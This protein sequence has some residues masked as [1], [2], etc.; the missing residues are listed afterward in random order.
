MLQALQTSSALHHHDSTA[1]YLSFFLSLFFS[2]L[3]FSLLLP[4]A[5]SL[6]RESLDPFPHRV[7][8]RT[9]RLVL[10]FAVL[11]TEHPERRPSKASHQFSLLPGFLVSLWVS[12]SEQVTEMS[13]PGDLQALFARIK[14][15]PS[16]PHDGA[17]PSQHLALGPQPPVGQPYDGQAQQ[18]YS[19]PFHG[20]HNPSVS[21][22][23]YTASPVPPHRTT[24]V[25]GVSSPRG[26][27]QRQVSADQSLN[28]LNLLKFSQK[29]SAPQQP[30]STV[31]AAAPQPEDRPAHTRALSASDLVASFA[32]KPAVDALKASTPGPTATPSSEKPAPKTAPGEDPQEF[33]LRLL[34][35][36]KAPEPRSQG[37][38]MAKGDQHEEKSTAERTPAVSSEDKPSEASKD[39]RRLQAPPS[40]SKSTIFT[41]VNPFDELAARSRSESPATG[42]HRAKRDSSHLAKTV[43]TSGHEDTAKA[44][45]STSSKETPKPAE[46]GNLQEHK[47]AVSETLGG[48][49][50]Q[51]D[52][53]VNAALNQPGQEEADRTKAEH[54]ASSKEP[55]PGTESVE[56]P[57]KAE[58]D[59]N[60]GENIADKDTSEPQAESAKDVAGETSDKKVADDWETAEDGPEKEQERVVR[61]FNFPLK[62]FISITVNP[63]KHQLPSI[64]I[65]GIMDVARLK[66]EFDQLD[67]C[68]TSATTEYIVYALAR[69]GG[70]RIIRQD[71]GRDKTVFRF[72]RDRVFNVTLSTNSPTPS[73]PAREQ[74]V[75]AI[76]VS[77]TVYWAPI[78]RGDED[79][80]EQDTM[81]S[82]C[83]VFPPYPASD[84]NPSGGQL[85]TRAKRSS[86][87]PEFFGIGRGKNIYIISPRHAASVTYGVSG[88]QRTV[89]TEK[90]LKE[91][92][93]KISTGK[94]G[95][96]FVFSEDDTVVA[97]LDKT[98]RL[99]FWD[100]REMDSIVNTGAT[101]SEIK[102]PI[103]T[104]V[105]GSPT[106]K[107]WP[108]SV[109]FID[110]LRPYI[111]SVAL[112]YV[113]VGLK[114]NHTL[115]LWDIG[116]GKAVQEL[117]FPHE[118]ESD[119]ICSVAYHPSSGIIVVGHPT[120]NSIYFVHLSAPR[121][122]LQAMSQAS[123]IK[124]VSE[125]DGSLPKPES[126]ACLSGIREISF[127]SKGQLRSLEILPIS[128]SGGAAQRSLEE[129][130]GLFEIY[131]MHSKGVTC[132]NIKKEDLG[133]TA[134]NKIIQPVDALEADAITV[135]D[136]QTFPSQIAD[137]PSVNGD[138][139]GTGTSQKVVKD[140]KKSLEDP[141]STAASPKIVARK[142]DEHAEATAAGKAKKK[143]EKAKETKSVASATTEVRT[144]SP[145]KSLA[146]TGDEDVP[147]ESGGAAEAAVN[148]HGSI[149]ESINLGITGDLIKQ[150]EDGVSGEVVKSL[151]RELETLH[152]RF[153][154]ERRAWDAASAVKYDQVLRLVSSTLSENV[155]KN[156]ARIISENIQA[157]VV[158][159]IEKKTAAT[160]AKQLHEAIGREL[161]QALP[162]EVRQALPESLSRA[163]QQPDVLRS[164]SEAVSSKVTSH[165]EKE[166]TRNLP[167][168]ITPAVNAAIVRQ[169]EKMAMTF[170]QQ[171][172]AQAEQYEAQRR[173]D[174]M[175]IDQ[176]S[177]LVRELAQTVS[178][179]ATAQTGLQ[180]EVARLSRQL[181]GTGTQPEQGPEPRERSPEEIEL[182]EIARL[183]NEGQYEEASVKVSSS[184]FGELDWVQADLVT[185][186]AIVAAGGPL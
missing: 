74:A 85:K 11:G 44:V 171:L 51:L 136:L 135:K 97:S 60:E 72:A 183:M 185:V 157:S 166:L 67:R 110:K 2:L 112:R 120:R 106:E 90:F 62:P 94:A 25:S 6:F 35:R 111:K 86:R 143:K 151:G 81:E 82:E 141:S 66:K 173:S 138:S 77:G 133:W 105:T 115:Q 15:C 165:V 30:P 4:V 126:T 8:L 76:G 91:R 152:K 63:A 118:N 102:V 21:S 9:S 53:E 93:L 55:P 40:T 59:K 45:A 49:A 146:T 54:D 95:K 142:I 129:E 130:V 33:L 144:T 174:S 124:R 182:A 64:R 137:E 160:V 149:T 43:D 69:N 84:E 61:V 145:T 39:S 156:L 164:I 99:R 26:D 65:D 88:K 147:A 46:Q 154:E 181:A 73:Q 132:L 71:D 162:R 117:Q 150:I 100:I 96:D 68:L 104:F 128:K 47:E 83:L 79:L 70:V 52:R 98:G 123:F 28:L 184:S 161:G 134:D 170:D 108:T 32:S 148:G 139:V 7:V 18:Q 113:L 50:G 116:L 31:G 122:T 179:V 78:L 153:E 1:S 169:T 75:I 14:P 180:N 168:V 101:P 155:E 125:K 38:E 37:Q 103:T 29:T 158:P 27:Q 172:K 92:A 177:S 23:N 12:T 24:D 109:L 5:V 121:Y 41:Y 159:A 107:S 57:T 34:G 58:L 20:Y 80:F 3:S 175:K 19:F 16:P 89:D 17:S 131:V 176:L 42:V 36:S 186:A 87:H 114:Q 163:V 48:L 56:A 10:L 22:P 127:A 178:S 13:T 167:S 119:P 140:T